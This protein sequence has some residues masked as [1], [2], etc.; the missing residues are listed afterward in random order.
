MLIKYTYYQMENNQ[1]MEQTQEE[2]IIEIEK[3]VVQKAQPTPVIYS[4]LLKRLRQTQAESIKLTESTESTE[5]SGQSAQSGQSGQSAQTKSDKSVKSSNQSKSKNVRGFKNNSKYN[6]NNH[7]QLPRLSKEDYQKELEN[8]QKVF[9][10]ELKVYLVEEF[11]EKEK[12]TTQETNNLGNNES[13]DVKD[14]KNTKSK[15]SK[16]KKPPMT[17]MERISKGIINVNIVRVI[18]S[19][20]EGNKL[21][22]IEKL[23]VNGQMDFVGKLGEYLAKYH[24]M[25]TYRTPKAI[26][27]HSP[28][29]KV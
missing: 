5:S 29:I 17:N 6:N 21:D 25:T 18:C 20:V 10:N 14:A 12:Q 13:K 4:D 26:L 2:Q 11:K 15:D 22:F 19:R 8:C 28:Y 24:I 1:E 23:I 27:L 9:M 3:D 7:T 16:S